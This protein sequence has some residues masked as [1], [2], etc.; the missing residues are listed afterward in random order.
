MFA[1]FYKVVVFVFDKTVCV[2]AILMFYAILVGI[3]FRVGRRVLSFRC[4]VW[5]LSV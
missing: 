1:L 2:M 3:F 5:S 4:G